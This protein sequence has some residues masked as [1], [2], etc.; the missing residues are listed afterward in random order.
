[1]ARWLSRTHQPVRLGSHLTQPF[2][3]FRCQRYRRFQL[4]QV[5]CLGDEMQLGVWKQ[6]SQTI[7][8]VDGDPRTLLTP[9]DRHRDVDLRVERFHPID[10]SLIGLSKLAIKRWLPLLPQ[11]GRVK[12]FM[13]WSGSGR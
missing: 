11:P 5:S 10:E 9:H 7:R 12:V 8:P 1:M 3:N 6:F 4:N 13:E 2:A